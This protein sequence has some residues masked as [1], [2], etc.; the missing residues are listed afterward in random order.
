MDSLS[1]T[2]VLPASGLA[3]STLC[4][5]FALSVATRP[6]EL[7]LRLAGDASTSITW[8]GYAERVR[9]LAG[10]LEQLGV[11]AGDTV[12][13]MLTNRPEFNLV[14]TAAMHLRATP[15]SIYNSSAPSQIEYLLGNAGSRV[16][17]T[18]RRF[19][20]VI[21]A[22]NP[23]AVEHVVIVE[24]GLP[25]SDVGDLDERRRAVDPADIA[26]IV[27]TSGTTG[28]PKGVQLSHRNLMAAVNMMAA[29]VPMREGGRFVSYLPAAHM[30]D[31]LM[32]HYSA[33]GTAA[34]IWTVPEP[35]MVVAGMLEARPTGMLAV[36]RIWEKLKSA[37][38]MAGCAEPSHLADEEKRSASASVGI[39]QL[40][41]G[42]S[43]GAP[44]GVD[45]LEYFLSL[46]IPIIEGWGL[47]EGSAIGTLNPPSD[48]RVGT[49]GRAV[50]G[51]EL[52]LADDGELLLRGENVMVGYRGNPTATSEAIDGEG[53]LHTGDVAEID[54]DSYVKIIDRKKELIIN[55]AGKNMS[56]ANI[57]QELKAASPLI[58]Q[59]CVIGDRRPY[60]VALLVLDPEH[61][62]AFASEHDL[63]DSSLSAL[64]E[65][66]EV[67]RAV[68]EAV[69][70]AN[71]QLSRVE[72]IKKFELLRTEWLPDGDE[73][74]PTAKLKRRAVAQKYSAEIDSLYG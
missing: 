43:G 72:Q 29:V 7:A 50:P 21:E 74:T 37:M 10:G 11:G 40:E 13:I 42:L 8:R 49:V 1:P 3:A 48:V 45:V 52:K 36:P 71:G 24:D 34:S 39:D 59:A 65:S 63:T 62:V 9:R 32:V 2:P 22:A 69:D 68:S 19:L 54:A 73:L 4:D 15:F 41:Y 47:T 70:R 31:R 25:E 51:V 46:D 56:P 12:A 38:E 30:A 64:A 28:P 53:W 61:A 16:V 18:E 55:A 20:E 57:E 5:A 35:S 33:L 44:I 58:G 6:D 26:T 23:S 60:N 14:D 67:R 17:V 66:A 27:Y